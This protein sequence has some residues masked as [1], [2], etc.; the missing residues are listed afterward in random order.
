MVGR[1]GREQYE[2]AV[3]DVPVAPSRIGGW[4]KKPRLATK[5]LTKTTITDYFKRMDD[6]WLG[7]P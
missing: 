6:S 4:S 7:S 3:I 1:R 5:G 2:G